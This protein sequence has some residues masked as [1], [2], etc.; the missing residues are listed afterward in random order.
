MNGRYFTALAMFVPILL[1]MTREKPRFADM[2]E[3]ATVYVFLPAS[4]LITLYTVVHV[5]FPFL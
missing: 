5:N 1:A 2:A 4:G 3:W